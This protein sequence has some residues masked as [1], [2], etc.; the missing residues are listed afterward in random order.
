MGTEFFYTPDGKYI[1]VRQ[2]K[3]QNMAT[4]NMNN[5]KMMWPENLK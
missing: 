2:S 4:D 1:G 5:N 3:P